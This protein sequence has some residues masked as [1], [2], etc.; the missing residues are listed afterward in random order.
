M[1][2]SKQVVA[3]M[4][5]RGSVVTKAQ[6]K[7]WKQYVCDSSQGTAEAGGPVSTF[8]LEVRRIMHPYV[9]D[10]AQCHAMILDALHF[11]LGMPVRARAAF[12]IQEWTEVAVELDRKSDA[13]AMKHAPAEA[14]RTYTAEEDATSATPPAEP[15][16]PSAAPAPAPASSREIG[17]LLLALGKQMICANAPVLT[18]STDVRDAVKTTFMQEGFPEERAVEL[19]NMVLAVTPAVEAPAVEAPDKEA[20]SATEQPKRSP[21]TRELNII[22]NELVKT[23]EGNTDLSEGEDDEEGNIIV[24]VCADDLLTG[25]ARRLKK[26]I[27]SELCWGASRHGEL[28]DCVNKILKRRESRVKFVLD[29]GINAE[30]DVT[31]IRAD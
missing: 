7:A 26:K 28:V 22:A 10:T 4:F 20:G 19:T 15:A 30:W 24:S 18:V 23:L 9:Y 5:K 17:V 21:Q 2:I 3:A 8:D 29:T 31:F 13:R 27:S 25:T 14:P 11:A 16:A 1:G 6:Y 12:K